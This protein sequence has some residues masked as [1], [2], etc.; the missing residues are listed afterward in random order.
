M[1]FEQQ[2]RAYVALG[3]N[4]GEP[5]EHLRAAVDAIDRLPTARV[6]MRSSLYRSAPVGCPPG[7][8]DYVNAV[9]AVDTALAPLALLRALLTIEAE[10]GRIRSTQNAPRTLDLDLLLHGDLV[11][12]SHELTLP[13]PRMH[14]R[15][16]VLYP[17]LEIAPDIVLPGLGQAGAYL[18]GVTDQAIQRSELL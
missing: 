17:L 7:Q 4:L 18:S 1:S 15:A 10:H 3:A 9:V 14:E 16:F 6:V 8:P 13:H 5:V 12:T 11:L 2:T